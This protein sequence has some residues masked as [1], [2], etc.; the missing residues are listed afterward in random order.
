MS[1]DFFDPN[2]QL[3]RLKNVENSVGQ[4]HFDH[5]NAT[6]TDVKLLVNEK[7]SPAKFK[8]HPFLV[9]TYEANSL[10]I[11]AVRKDLFAAGSELFADLEVK[12]ECSCGKL[13]DLQFWKL[14][15][16]CGKLL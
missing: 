5:N 1:N 6:E 2:E 14:C 16:Y 10:T 7:I 11:K 15:P 13:L 8:P 4:Q 12:H 9:N 3:N